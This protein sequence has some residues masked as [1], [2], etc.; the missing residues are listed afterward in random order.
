M[1]FD[2]DNGYEI[3]LLLISPFKNSET[4]SEGM[5]MNGFPMYS[6]IFNHLA[7]IDKGK[8]ILG[9][10]PAMEQI[11]ISCHGGETTHLEKLNS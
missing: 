2:P 3:M 9:S 6:S 1:L 7:G 8:L 5:W 4:E 10:D 11:L